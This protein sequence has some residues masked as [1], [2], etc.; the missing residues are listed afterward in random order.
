MLE[1]LIA[2]AIGFFGSLIVTFFAMVAEILLRL[3]FGD[4]SGVGF[5]R[6]LFWTLLAIW[7]LFWI[8]G[9]WRE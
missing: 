5:R 3:V 1:L 4:A 9:L 6:G 8:V 7:M 2:L